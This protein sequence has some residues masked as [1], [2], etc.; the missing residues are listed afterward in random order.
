MKGRYGLNLF[1]RTWSFTDRLMAMRFA[2]RKANIPAASWVEELMAKR[3]GALIVCSGCA[4]KYLDGLRRWG[5]TRHPDMKAQ[6]N[7]CDFCRGV[8]PYPMP[9]WMAEEHR[10]PSQADYAR[11]RATALSPF[12]RNFRGE[13]AVA[14]RPRPRTGSYVPAQ[15]R[16]QVICIP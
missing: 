9:L 8:E 13:Q 16:R 2:P 6:G 15:S 11:R 1:R 14:P 10:Y 12:P 7:A 4:R 3:F 5:Y